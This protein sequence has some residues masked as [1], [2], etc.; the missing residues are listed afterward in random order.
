MEQRIDVQEPSFL[1]KIWSTSTLSSVERTSRIPSSTNLRLS[2]SSTAPSIVIL[3][4]SRFVRPSLPGLQIAALAGQ[5]EA[6]NSGPSQG[7]GS[8]NLNDEPVSVQ[9]LM[10]SQ[11]SGHPRG[12]GQQRCFNGGNRGGNS[13]GSS[14][15]YLSGGGNGNRGYNH[16]G[17]TD[18]Q[19]YRQD[20][21]FC[22]QFV[23]FVCHCIRLPGYDLDQFFDNISCDAIEEEHQKSKQAT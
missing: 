15:V 14:I 4:F 2:R 20:F 7:S 19:G 10:N 18:G 5:N 23:L 8:Q 17:Y 1:P 9:N 12:S 11:Q 13:N 3:L 6:S 22:L 16:G 21:V